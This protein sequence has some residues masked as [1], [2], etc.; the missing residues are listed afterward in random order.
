MMTSRQA[1][2]SLVL[3]FPVAAKADNLEQAAIVS[4]VIGRSAAAFAAALAA[5]PKLLLT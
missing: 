4:E 1:I 2:I 5:I 3:L